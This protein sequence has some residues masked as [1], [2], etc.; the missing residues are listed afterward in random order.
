MIRWLKQAGILSDEALNLVCLDGDANQTVS[1][2]SAHAELRGKW[3]ALLICRALS[4]LVQKN[5]C[6]CQLAGVP[7]RVNNYLRAMGC[8]IAVWVAIY[9]LTQ[10]T[11]RLGSFG[12]HEVLV[13]L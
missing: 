13:L 10:E 7:M 5:H 2:N 1:D 3:W 12:A 11:L 8:I 9:Y 4:F 6:Q